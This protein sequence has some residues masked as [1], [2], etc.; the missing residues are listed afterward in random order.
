MT[1]RKPS[2]ALAIRLLSKLPMGTPRG[3]VDPSRRLYGALMAKART[4]PRAQWVVDHEPL[5]VPVSEDGS[6]TV[7]A[8][9]DTVS[10]LSVV[11]ERQ[12]VGAGDWCAVWL[13]QPLDVVLAVIALTGI[14][15]VPV[16]LSAKLDPEVAV[17]LMRSV[18]QGV[19]LLAGRSLREAADGHGLTAGLRLDWERVT[20]EAR[21][22]APPDPAARTQGAVRGPGDPYVVTHT[23]GTTGTPKLA[24]HTVRSFYEQAAIQRKVVRMLRLRG[25]LAISLTPVHVRT[26]SA[27]LAI[28]LSR[29]P[30]S[31][32]MCRSEDPESIRRMLLRWRP[33]YLETHPNTFVLWEDLADSGALESVRVFLATFD[34]T[35]PRTV[36]RM[37]AGSRRRKPRFVEVYA[38]SESGPLA[39]RIWAGGKRRDRRPLPAVTS[40]HGVGWAVP[41]YCKIRLV[42]DQGAD[43][44][45]G[46]PGR[47][48]ARARGRFCGYLNVPELFGKNLTADG[49]WDT[50]D[51]GVLDSAGQ[52][53]LIDRQVERLSQRH[54]AIALEGILMHRLPEL[55]EAVVIEAGHCLV[56]AVATRDGVPVS[57]DRWATATDDLPDFSAPVLVDWA[58]I[59][60]TMTGKV[61][62]KV[63]RQQLAELSRSGSA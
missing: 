52:L 53:H 4:R 45:R 27:A 30:V 43:A 48:L 33:S 20:A 50:G 13:E 1:E 11:L 44:G 5:A 28:L 10:R 17:E 12:G 15:A 26:L 42:D 37:L 24:I 57:G 41:G 32:I 23:S 56:P 18:P 36:E 38:Q 40:G 51:Y 14:G 63:L 62:R 25:H 16:A 47:I 35:H 19:S 29:R 7:R 34:A 61:R 2:Y 21:R 8:L 60:R 54:S 55:A 9:A 31:P 58:D 46:Q 22:E 3:P 49:W 39:I 59:P 6:V